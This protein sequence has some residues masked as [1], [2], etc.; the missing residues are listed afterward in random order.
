MK[1][2]I[3]LPALAVCLLLSA[4]AAGEKETV[5]PRAAETKQ[6]VI[7]SELEDMQAIAPEDIESITYTRY[8]EGGAFSGSVT[9]AEN[10]KEICRCLSGLSLGEENNVG[11]LDDGLH[12]TVK[13]GGEPLTLYF[14]GDNFVVDSRQYAAE[15]LSPLK[16]YIDQLIAAET[17]EATLPETTTHETSE[18]ETTVQKATA[19]ETTAQETTA[20]DNPYQNFDYYNGYAFES[21]GQLKYWIEFQ[22]KFYLHCLFRSG[23]PEPYEEVYTLYPDWEAS[24]AQQLTIRTVEDANGNDITAWF[25]SLD[26]LF[27]S[28]DIVVMQVKRNEQT[29]AGGADDNILTGEYILKPREAKTPEQL[30]AMAQEYYQRNYDFYPP[31]ADFTDNGDG[32]YTIH[33]YEIMD[34]GEGVFHTATSAWYTVD[35]YGAGINEITGETVDLTG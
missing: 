23:E 17:E 3:F 6:P 26:F 28:E 2:K 20:Q 31:E 8:T 15:G 30:C 13:A 21:G 9:D 33:L 16:K 19:Q 7:P 11:T 32:T 14:E 1:L 4:C 5:K 27:S 25:E 22:D 18:Q 34:L 24:P 10:I 12:L 29:L 35:A